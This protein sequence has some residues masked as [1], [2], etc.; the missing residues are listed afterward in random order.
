[1]LREFAG[2]WKR[3]GLAQS[4]FDETAAQTG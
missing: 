4:L 3:M 2:Y 1:M